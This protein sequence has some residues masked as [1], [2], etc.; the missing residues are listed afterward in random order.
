MSWT[1]QTLSPEIHVFREFPGTPG[2]APSL[3]ETRGGKAA[4]AMSRYAATSGTGGIWQKG[5]GL[6][7]EW[8]GGPSPRPAENFF[9]A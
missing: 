1:A 9:S 4:L 6:E 2:T 3:C 8:P 7:D 5:L